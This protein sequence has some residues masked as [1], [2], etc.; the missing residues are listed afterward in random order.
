[1]FPYGEVRDRV[2]GSTTVVRTRGGQLSGRA[3]FGG[4]GIVTLYC[5]LPTRIGRNLTIGGP[6]IGVAYYVVPDC[7]ARR[8]LH[9]Y[10][11]HGA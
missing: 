10:S 7:G 9:Q 8:E 2:S 4:A 6:R 11:R 3:E 1:M 5:N